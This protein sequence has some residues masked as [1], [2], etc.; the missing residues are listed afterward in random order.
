MPCAGHKK[1][2][3]H[4]RNADCLFSGIWIIGIILSFFENK[5]SLNP[6]LGGVGSYILNTN[7]FSLFP[8]LDMFFK[9]NDTL[10]EEAVLPFSV[11]VPPFSTEG[12]S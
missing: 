11:S 2:P 10:S 1:A 3:V 7:V 4:H 6:V 9:M 8:L 12:Y 5:A